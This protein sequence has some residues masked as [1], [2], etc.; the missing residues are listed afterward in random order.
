MHLKPN[1]EDNGVITKQF[2]KKLCKSDFKQ[3]YSTPELNDILYLHYK[4]FNQIANLE[5][6]TGIKQYTQD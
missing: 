3:Y 2:L 5:E 6:Y 1:P 4:G